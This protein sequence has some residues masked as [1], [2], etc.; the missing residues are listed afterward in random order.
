MV[1]GP[2][3][4]VP[5]RVTALSVTEQAFDSLLNPIQ[6]RVSLGLRALTFPE[7]LQAGTPF[8]VLGIVNQVAKEVLARS[9]VFNSAEQIGGMVSF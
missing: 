6:A 4:V 3:R 1:W 7:L 9:N 2:V 5:V 8:E